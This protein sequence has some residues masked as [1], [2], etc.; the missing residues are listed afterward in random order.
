MP[1]IISAENVLKVF[2]KESIAYELEK[3]TDRGAYTQYILVSDDSVQKV[4]NLTLKGNNNVK[5]L[6]S[7]EISTVAF[8][9]DFLNKT[10]LIVFFE[11]N[12]KNSN[13]E[14]GYAIVEIQTCT[15]DDL[16]PKN[17]SQILSQQEKDA[18]IK[19]IQKNKDFKCANDLDESIL[20]LANDSWLNEL[21]NPITTVIE[22][23]SGNKTVTTYPSTFK[24]KMFYTFEVGN[25]E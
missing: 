3:S 2:F 12:Q 21:E 10:K 1:R 20:S 23:S 15:A 19:E 18:L 16:L 7:S 22:N 11:P 4:K 25:F 14:I 13:N 5:S 17:S 9:F 8:K 6:N 24:Y